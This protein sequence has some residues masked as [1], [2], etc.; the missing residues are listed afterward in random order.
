MS[1]V[2]LMRR[3]GGT[4]L[5]FRITRREVGTDLSG[6]TGKTNEITVISG[7]TL[8]DWTISAAEP[9]LPVQ[10][11]IWIKTATASKNSMEILK[12]NSIELFMQG[13]FQYETGAWVRKKAYIWQD[14]AWHDF[15]IFLF[16]N[17]DQCTALTGGWEVKKLASSDT[18]IY[19]LYIRFARHGTSS[20]MSIAHT[21][22]AVDLS[23]YTSLKVKLTNMTA[24]STTSETNR[25]KVAIFS[26]APTG[27]TWSNLSPVTYMVIPND[28]TL[29]ETV[30]TLDV[31]GYKNGSY[32]VGIHSGGYTNGDVT[33]VWLE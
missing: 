22:S 7:T 11:S 31:S 14:G 25:M 17:G 2:F 28:T 8:A 21:T 29:T 9:P 4:N 30:P 12:K 6:I 16:D 23:G 10:G 27:A 13:C 5:N 32:F 19:D 3:G 24:T 26:T 20:I 15:D 18:A 33:E 1:D